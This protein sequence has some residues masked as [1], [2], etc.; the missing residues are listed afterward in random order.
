MTKLMMRGAL[1]SHHY[2]HDPGQSCLLALLLVSLLALVVVESSMTELEAPH[3]L[4]VNGLLPAVAVISDAMPRFSFMHSQLSGMATFGITQA[5]YRITVHK[6]G[7]SRA[8]ATGDLHDY[9]LMWDSGGVNGTNCTQ[10]VYAGR[11]LIAFTRYEWTAQ[12]TASGAFG[13]SAVA[14]ATFET[15]PMATTDWHGAAWLQGR[16][17]QYRRVFV[18]PA[19]TEVVWARAYVAALGC[20]HVEVNGAVPQPDLMGMCPWSVT[21]NL[22]A[23]PSASL[24]VRYVTH[25]LSRMLKVRATVPIAACIPAMH[26]MFFSVYV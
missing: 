11:A 5:S 2:H 19:A 4:K 20:A 13:S 23:D 17:T 22:E 7:S 6:V 8:A 3:S 26:F 24:N 12:W 1:R 14:T 15:G 21:P 25:N 9:N 18:L 10:I 16:K